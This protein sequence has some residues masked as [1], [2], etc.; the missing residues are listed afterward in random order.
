MGRGVIDLILF[1]RADCCL[2]D[3]GEWIVA[4]VAR[5][6][7][8]T[9]EKVDIDSDPDLVAKYGER[10]PVIATRAGEVLAEGR[11]SERELKRRLSKVF[12]PPSS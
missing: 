4:R 10:I 2:C 9:V 1:G 7:P 6:I 5:R 3:S 11:I 8:L 12:S